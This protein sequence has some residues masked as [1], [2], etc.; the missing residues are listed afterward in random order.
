MLVKYSLDSHSSEMTESLS[1]ILSEIWLSQNFNLPI[2]TLEAQF[3]RQEGCCNKEDL[4]CLPTW[5]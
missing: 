2:Y 1:L 3:S 4:E 5:A